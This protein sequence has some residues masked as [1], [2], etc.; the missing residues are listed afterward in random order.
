MVGGLRWLGGV[1]RDQGRHRVD[2]PRARS[3][4]CEGR[5]HRQHSLAG[6]RR[7]TDAPQRDDRRG[8][9][10]A[11]RAGPARLHGGALRPRRDGCLPRL[12]PRPIHHRRD[13]QRQ[14]RLADFMRNI[15]KEC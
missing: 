1:R 5:H 14:R 9:A 6:P 11:A 10:A 3:Q 15:S 12:R 8:P 4:L 2:V 13:D 7:H